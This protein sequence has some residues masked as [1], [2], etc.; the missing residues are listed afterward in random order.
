MPAVVSASGPRGAE[1]GKSTRPRGFR[2]GPAVPELLFLLLAPTA[3]TALGPRLINTDGDLGRHLRVGETILRDGIMHADRFSFTRFG[4]RFVP[5][6]W[7]SEVCFALANRVGGLPGVAVFSAIVIGATY[8]LLAAFLLRRGA[9]P[10]L[11]YVLGMLAAVLGSIHWLARP[12]L[13]SLLAT[14]LLLELAE[15]DTPRSTWWFAPLF[16]LW[17]NLHGAFL[18]GLVILAMYLVGDLLEARRPGSRDAWSRRARYHGM[19]LGIGLLA[20]LATPA[21]MGLL[22]HVAGYLGKSFLVDVTEEYRS[23][24]FHRLSGRFFLVVVLGEMTVLALVR[25]R[26]SWPVLLLVLANT[27][28]ALHSQRNIPLFGLVTVP[29]LGLHVDPSWRRARA[30]LLVRCREAFRVGETAASGRFVWAGA[31]AL[32]LSALAAH[33]GRIGTTQVLVDRFDPARFPVSVVA[34]AR[35]AGLQGRIFNELSWGGYLLYAWPEQRVFIDAQTDFY[36]EELAS[37]YLEV[38]TLAPGWRDRLQRW[39]AS[40]VLFPAGSRLIS[41]LQRDPAWRV[42]DADS[43]AVLLVRGT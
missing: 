27:A 20:T 40:I 37:E 29:L 4:A 8:A 1:I 31:T 18:F 7:L 28:F 35:A 11:T 5:Y 6:E 16:A 10:L 38:E 26:L 42:W 14:V 41:E 36:G 34:R 39:G 19:A 33:G 23:P 22:G 13:F 12:H 9:D 15:R 30:R 32:L 25:R 43:T 17:A 3:A 21:G 2:F 24:D